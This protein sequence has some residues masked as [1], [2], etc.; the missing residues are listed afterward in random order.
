[1]STSDEWD[2]AAQ[3]GVDALTAG[4]TV[5]EKEDLLREACPNWSEDEVRAWAR[6]MNRRPR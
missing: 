2:P 5:E 6:G 3:D 4:M 1:M